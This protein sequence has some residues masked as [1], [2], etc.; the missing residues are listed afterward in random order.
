MGYASQAGRARTNPSNPQAHAICDRCGFRYNHVD[1]RWQYDWRGAS[2][3]NLR[4]L[5]CPTCYDKAQ[6]QL[7]SI[8]LPADPVP[9]NNPR[10]QI[11]TDASN[12]IRA[13]SGQD[14][15]APF[16]GI[17]VPGNVQRITED[18]AY[19]V[20]QQVG[21]TASTLNNQPG[22]DQN[23]AMYPR[24]I[25]LASITADGTV[26]ITVVTS[27]AHGLTTGDQIAIEGT[28]LSQTDGFYNVDVVD[29]TTFTYRV[30]TAIMIGTSLLMPTTIL[31]ATNAG[32]PYQMGIP[33]T[34]PL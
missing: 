11:F 31:T 29:G 17:P 1:L 6:N 10:V 32:T 16:V 24:A 14:T 21:P 18:D 3:A 15:V 9:V 27:A 25:A 22:L 20:T 19:R 26:N 2:L 28:S 12:D 5:V 7:R 13:T 33:Q 34:G 30:A 4:I 8:V 23:A